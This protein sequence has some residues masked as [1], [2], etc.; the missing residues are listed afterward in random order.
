MRGFALSVAGLCLLLSV[1]AQA[2]PRCDSVDSSI[3]YEKVVRSGETSTYFSPHMNIG[4]SDVA[5]YSV[6]S[7]SDAVGICKA[8]GHVNGNLGDTEPSR[9]SELLITLNS[10]GQVGNIKSGC[11]NSNCRLAAVTVTCW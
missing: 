1:K 3:G 9:D 5:R 11:I 4:G 7:A 6:V 8:L 10:N 2:A